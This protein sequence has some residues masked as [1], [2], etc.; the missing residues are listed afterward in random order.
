MLKP[1]NGVLLFTV[2]GANAATSLRPRQHEDLISR[3]FLHLTSTKLRG[4]V[5]PN[6]HTTWHTESYLAIRLA[7][8]FPRVEYNVIIDGVQ[9]VVLAYKSTHS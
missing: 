9:D 7:P 3:G 6:Y 2:H 8:L 1:N 4:I 5:P